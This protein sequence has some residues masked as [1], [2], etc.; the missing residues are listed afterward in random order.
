[1]ISSLCRVKSPLHATLPCPGCLV[2]AHLRFCACSSASSCR[3]LT[4]LGASGPMAWSDDTQAAPPEPNPARPDMPPSRSRYISEGEREGWVR[5]QERK[6]RKSEAL[7]VGYQLDVLLL[8][9]DMPHTAA[10]S[11]GPLVIHPPPLALTPPL[12]PLPFRPLPCLC[13]DSPSPGPWCLSRSASARSPTRVEYSTVMRYSSLLTSMAWG[14]GRWEGGRSGRGG[15][16]K[17]ASTRG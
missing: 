9:H 16:E 3:C 2:V 15:E 13:L 5:K 12:S 17:V 1:M 10:G 8:L 14:T 6:G 11:P 4:W 7:R